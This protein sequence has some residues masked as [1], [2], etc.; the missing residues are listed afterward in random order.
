MSLREGLPAMIEPAKQALAHMQIVTIMPSTVS[1]AWPPAISSVAN[2]LVSWLAFDLDLPSIECIWPQ[3]IADKIGVSLVCALLLLGAPP[4]TYA[5]THRVNAL[6]APLVAPAVLQS[7]Y[8]YCM[9]TYLVVFFVVYA[10]MSALA[11][12]YFTCLSLIHI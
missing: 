10:P 4:L 9:S 8:Q 7:F 5:A 11:F 2:S 3:T 1:I 6:C 12:K